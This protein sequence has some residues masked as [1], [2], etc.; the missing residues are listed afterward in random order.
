MARTAA[1]AHRLPISLVLPLNKSRMYKVAAKTFR[2]PSM[3]WPIGTFSSLDDFP[4]RTVFVNLYHFKTPV[5][6]TTYF[7]PKQRKWTLRSLDDML[8]NPEQVGFE[9]CK[10]L[11]GL[12][13]IAWHHR[14]V[15]QSD[16]FGQKLNTVRIRVLQNLKAKQDG[17]VLF[18]CH[19]GKKKLPLFALIVYCFL[20][21]FY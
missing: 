10:K 20:F 8:D 7:I 21:Y 5:K 4:F 17:T 14:K 19:G 3:R 13:E 9:F 6:S 2:N 1:V 16:K 15:I 11:E 18:H 12:A